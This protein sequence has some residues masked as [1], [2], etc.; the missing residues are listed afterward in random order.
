MK[1]IL[2]ATLLFLFFVLSSTAMAQQVYISSGFSRA[3]FEDYENSKS[4]TNLDDTGYASP[5]KYVFESG[6]RM[7]IYKERVKF[8]A[9]FLYHQ[10]EINT[11][12]ISGGS[13][14]P[15]TYELSYVGLK[16]GFRMNLLRWKKLKLQ[17]HTHISKDWLLYGSNTYKDIFLDLF[18]DKSIARSVTNFHRG[19]GFEYEINDRIAVFTNYNLSTSFKD[20]SGDSSP[21]EKYYFTTKAVQI[22]VLFNISSN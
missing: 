9:G 5:E 8:E 10:H 15:T 11:A 7:N 18:E 2:H 13:K 12:F 22:G 21:G 3:A 17:V 14:I 4:E 1:K 19:F 16:V 20:G 6:F